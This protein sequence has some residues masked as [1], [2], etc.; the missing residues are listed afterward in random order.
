MLEEFLEF[1]QNIDT[2]TSYLSIG[3]KLNDNFNILRFE[4]LN[5]ELKYFLENIDC[6]FYPIHLNKKI[7][8]TDHQN[9]IDTFN[10]RR[11]N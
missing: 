6:N 3:D 1:I 8:T 10:L 2:Q 7:N 11:E 4:N 9:L 5:N